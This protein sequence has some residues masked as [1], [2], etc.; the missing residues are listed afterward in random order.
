MNIYLGLEDTKNFRWRPE[1][2]QRSP[3][4]S[5]AHN[6]LVCSQEVVQDLLWSLDASILMKEDSLRLK[7]NIKEAWKPG[8]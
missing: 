8:L 1:L 4:A 7:Q 6:L 5:E 3:K 2:V